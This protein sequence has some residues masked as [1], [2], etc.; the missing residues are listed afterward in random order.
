MMVGIATDPRGD[1]S[2]N[3]EFCGHDPDRDP[4]SPTIGPTIAAGAA[5]VSITAPHD[6]ER[7]ERFRAAES[8][9]PSASVA[10]AFELEISTTLA[11]PRRDILHLTVA[12]PDRTAAVY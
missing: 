11:Y 3:S 8:A 12:T 2:K 1:G 4:I 5:D 9:V 7:P 10:A 6:V